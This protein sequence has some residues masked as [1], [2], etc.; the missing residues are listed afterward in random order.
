MHKE[1]VTGYV[2]DF[3]QMKPEDMCRSERLKKRLL[4]TVPE[5]D[6][7]R[8]RLVTDCLLYTSRCV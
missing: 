2:N 4:D 3:M 6:S 1:Q 5:V 7:E 8:M